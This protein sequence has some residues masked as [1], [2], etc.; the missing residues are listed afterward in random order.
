MYRMGRSKIS[1]PE[2]RELRS[3]RRSPRQLLRLGFDLEDPLLLC[4][5]TT[6]PFISVAMQNPTEN[7]CND[8]YNK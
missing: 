3:W 1:G 4:L 6:K 8:G 7:G 2:R 5:T